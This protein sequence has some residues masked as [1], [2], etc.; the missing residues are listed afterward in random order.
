MFSDS[1][2]IP[3]P[4]KLIN[5][6]LNKK[7]AIFMQNFFVYKINIF[8]QHESPWEGTKIC[9]KKNLKS[10]T[11]L[12]KKIQ[13]K[14]LKKPF[15]KLNNEKSIEIVNNGGWHF[16]NLYSPE[17]ISKKLQ[18]F[19]HKEYSGQEFSN[20]SVIEQKIMNLEDLFNRG[21]KYQKI[22]IRKYLP[23]YFLDNLNYFK[24]YL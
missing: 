19:P 14:N 15:W 6:K 10:F 12:R 22:D 9:K 5:F 16:N 13:K 23:K 3:N 24:N 1:D 20:K 11:Y 7:F 17:I 2:E 8:N 21:H 18:I 4:S